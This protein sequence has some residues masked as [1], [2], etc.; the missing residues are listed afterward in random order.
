MHRAAITFLGATL[1]AL[2]LF[3]QTTAP[4][5]SEVVELRPAPAYFLEALT[6]LNLAQALATQCDTLSI[7]PVVAQGLTDSVLERLEADGFDP[8]DPVSQMQD[9]AP[10]LA[11][12]Q[13]AFV[14]RHN[15]TGTQRAAYCEAGLT[16]LLNQTGPGQYLTAVIE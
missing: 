8:N 2:P 14:E 15:L 7:D 1:M 10:D 13:Q 6:D 9:S 4:T 3:A 5:E 16:D 11:T 12:L